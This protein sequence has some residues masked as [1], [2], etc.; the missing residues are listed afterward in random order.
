MSG[1]TLQTDECGCVS[2]DTQWLKMCP[3]HRAE[4]DAVSQRWA[5][6]RARSNLNTD[7]EDLL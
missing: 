5:N 6:D 3:Q 7:I 4:T 2:N 1:Q